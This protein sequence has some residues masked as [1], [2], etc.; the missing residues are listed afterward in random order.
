MNHKVAERIANNLAAVKKAK[1]G[2]FAAEWW[3]QRFPTITEKDYLQ[4]L[5]ILIRRK[6]GPRS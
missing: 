6:G 1:G 3:Q 2:K 4:V 5:E